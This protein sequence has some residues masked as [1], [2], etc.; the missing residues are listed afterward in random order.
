MCE[1]RFQMLKSWVQ[2]QDLGEIEIEEKYVSWVRSLR[3][4]R[5]VTAIPPVVFSR[6]TLK[7]YGG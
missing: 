1:L 6:V 5:Y 3:T 4:D 2:N 7:V